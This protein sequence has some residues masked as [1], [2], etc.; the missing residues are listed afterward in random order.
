VIAVVDTDIFIDHLRQQ[1]A[2][3]DVLRRL[4]EEGPV[5]A[6][7]VTRVELR[8]G[9]RG[10]SVE[11]ERLIAEILWEQAGDDIADRAG[12]FARQFRASHPGIGLAD[13]IVAAT[14]DVMGAE[15]VTRNV[16]HYPM[17]P[18]LQPAY[19]MSE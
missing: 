2:A 1:T 15:I 8:A 14:A 11:V 9:S 4:H 16:R 17:F 6:S 5:R 19:G 18:D 10:T 3:R 13:F 12:A 7:V